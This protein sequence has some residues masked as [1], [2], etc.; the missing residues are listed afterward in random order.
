MMKL[1]YMEIV[2]TRMKVVEALRELNHADVCHLSYM[3]RIL[4]IHCTMVASILKV[5]HAVRRA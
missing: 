3:R 2:V 5:H 4:A 1:T